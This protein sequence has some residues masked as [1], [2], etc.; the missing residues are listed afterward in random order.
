VVGGAIG[1]VW[2]KLSCLPS[3][4]RRIRRHSNRS[5][6]FGQHIRNETEVVSGME[7]ANL[8]DDAEKRLRPWREAFTGPKSNPKGRWKQAKRYCRRRRC[9]ANCFFPFVCE[10]AAA[11]MGG[12]P[13]VLPR[14]NTRAPNGIFCCKQ[15]LARMQRPAIGG[16][17][18]SG[19]VTCSSGGRQ[20]GKWL[21]GDISLFGVH[22]QTW[23]LVGSVI[24]LFGFL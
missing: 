4:N 13:C 24:I 17:V 5:S 10:R 16:G 21:I 22:I 7:D 2:G 14:L 20:W 19:I 15:V 3:Q 12:V 23:M 11:C 8:W 9:G 18:T 1:A 6:P